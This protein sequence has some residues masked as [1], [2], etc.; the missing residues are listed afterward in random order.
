[1]GRH[2]KSVEQH[3]ADGTYRPDRHS[4]RNEPRADG[5]PERP[6]HLSPAAVEYWEREVPR[7]I[8]NGTAKAQDSAA[9]AAM[10]EAYAMYVRIWVAVQEDPIDK[11]TRMACTTWFDRWFALAKDFGLTPLARMKL[12]LPPVEAEEEEDPKLK[13]FSETA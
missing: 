9:L 8:A 13:F 5:V 12:T 7:L 11:N 1:M 10:A 3:H 2:K 6:D 4:H